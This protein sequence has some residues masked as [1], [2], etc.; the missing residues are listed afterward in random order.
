MAQQPDILRISRVGKVTLLKGS[1]L[2]N[3]TISLSMTD[4]A[5]KELRLDIPFL[6][7]VKLRP[8]LKAADQDVPRPLR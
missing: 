8:R 7:A 5:G 1:T 6:E 4:E 3:S 2:E